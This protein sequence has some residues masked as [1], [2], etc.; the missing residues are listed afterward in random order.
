MDGAAVMAVVAAEAGG[1]DVVMVLT[2]AALAVWAEA[3]VLAEVVASAV[4]ARGVGSGSA[5]S[6]TTYAS[7]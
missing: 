3:T 1:M 7:G 6:S 2:S 4:L 5:G